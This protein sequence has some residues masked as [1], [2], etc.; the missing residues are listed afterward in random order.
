VNKEVGWEP[1]CDCGETKTVPAIILDPF[2]G[3]GTTAICAR[4]NNRDF[5]GIDLNPKY[6]E[7]AQRR[8]RRFIGQGLHNDPKPDTANENLDDLFS[9]LV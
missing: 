6:V 1:T 3:A 8:Y 2:M 9:D 5:I 7:L 4:K